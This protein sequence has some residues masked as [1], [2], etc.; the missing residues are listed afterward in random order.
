[1]LGGP[2]SE[3]DSCDVDEEEQ[4]VVTLEEGL[5]REVRTQLISLQDS[6]IS[7]VLG[8]IITFESILAIASHKSILVRTEA[9]KLLDLYVKRV[10]EGVRVSLVQSRAFDL[11]ANQLKDHRVSAPLL[12]A[13]FSI[14]F[15]EPFSISGNS[16]IPSVTSLPT[17]QISALIPVLACLSKTVERPSLCQAVIGILSQIYSKVNKMATFFFEN[18]GVTTLC[19]VVVV[20]W[21]TPNISMEEKNLLIKE[22]LQFMFAIANQS[23]R[24]SVE[25]LQT[26]RALLVCLD[27][28]VRQIRLR[29][30]RGKV[31]ILARTLHLLELLI[32][33]HVMSQTTVPHTTPVHIKTGRFSPR[34][35]PLKSSLH[36][37]NPAHLSGEGGDISS[38]VCE[39]LGVAVKHLLF[40]DHPF[41][42]QD[43][44]KFY[45][46]MDLSVQSV[47]QV[48][49]GR[50][51]TDHMDLAFAKFLTHYLH[52]SVYG[53]MT[54]TSHSHSH[55]PGSDSG[56]APHF[57]LSAKSALCEQYSTLLVCMLSPGQP[58][59]LHSAVFRYMWSLTGQKDVL[60]GLLTSGQ[61][62]KVLSCRLI[63]V[64]HDLL[65]HNQADDHSLSTL[66]SEIFDCVV[67]Q[68]ESS[69]IRGSLKL[70]TLLNPAVEADPRVRLKYETVLE[71]IKM[72]DQKG[73][74]D[75]SLQKKDWLDH[76]SKLYQRQ[77]SQNENRSR[78]I[79]SACDSVT[80]QTVSQQD[81]ARRNILVSMK[82]N[83]ATSHQ[84][85]KTWRR[86]IMLSTTPRGL[87]SLDE[88]RDMWYQVDPTEGPNRERRRLMRVPRSVPA[89][90]FLP[91]AVTAKEFDP[92]LHYLFE[93]V[94]PA[95]SVEVEEDVLSCVFDCLAIWPDK[96]CKGR[97]IITSNKFK[98]YGEGPL[99][100]PNMTKYLP[101]DEETVYQSWEFNEIVEYHRR[102]HELVDN[103]LEFFLSTGKT[104][105]LSFHSPETRNEVVSCMT[106]LVLPNLV[107]SGEGDSMKLK[108][109]TA[110]WQQGEMTNFEYLM[111]L[112]KLAGRSF[113]DLMQYP[114]FPFILSDYTSHN[115]NFLEPS[116]FRNFSLPI[117]VQNE[118]NIARYQK[119]YKE[120]QDV[121]NDDDTFGG[122]SPHHYSSHYSNSS[123]VLHYLVRI[124]PFT[125]LFLDFQGK[126]FD[127]ADRTFHSLLTS[128]ELS[129]SKS[130]SDVKELIPEFFYFPEFLT[131]IHGLN[132]GQRQTG[133]LVSD[134]ILPP[135]AEESARLFVLKHRQALESSHVSKHLHEW[136]DLIFGFK[137]QGRAAVAATNVFHPSTY[138]I[139]AA[140]RSAMDANL[141]SR[142]KSEVQM[143]GQMPLQL[144]KDPHPARHRTTVLRE[145][146]LKI[147]S[148]LRKIQES[149]SLFKN[150]T[151]ILISRHMLVCRP[152]LSQQGQDFIG[153]DEG[154]EPVCVY[155]EE[156]EFNH[157]NIFYLSGGEERVALLTPRAAFI[158]ASSRTYQ[159]VVVTWGNWD[160]AVH[161]LAFDGTVCKL[162]PPALDRLTCVEGGC[163]GQVLFT[164]GTLGVVSCWKLANTPTYVRY[165]GEVVH[166][167]G[168]EGPISCL[169][170]CRPFSIAVS[171]SVD[172][173]A[174]IWDTNRL[175]YVATLD[176]HEG[177]VVAMATSPTM[178]DIA[179]ATSKRVNGVLMSVLRIWTVN[180]TFVKS[181]EVYSEV[182][183]LAYT[184]A[185]EGVFVNSIVGGLRNGN[186][187]MWSSWDLSVIRDL[188]CPLDTSVAVLSL[189][190]SSSS[191]E[192]YAVF[193]DDTIAV[194]VKPE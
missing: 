56:Y 148:L 157:P 5:L 133:Q 60:G 28:Y 6:K 61:K 41:I 129:S 62:R 44:Q 79:E 92:P 189:T 43:V 94:S 3:G 193:K 172:G 89:K 155:Q 97:L 123:T 109:I 153:S 23:L 106:K 66:L 163:N 88:R 119:H 179:T 192:L 45:E 48:V 168:H 21:M 73:T 190:I 142:W 81:T 170:V 55:L 131:N 116:V 110:S 19:Q 188:K 1:M 125:Q 141:H 54:K 15:G 20:I 59:S 35:G 96:C 72:V 176:G 95:L 118:S 13:L 86:I 7:S 175:S 187:R 36:H 83:T 154:A 14:T 26:L 161:I 69:V 104:I 140:E 114:V 181:T 75:V 38:R 185:P 101:S 177:S 42:E 130:L 159:S 169:S 146:M 117:A 126:S 58:R 17:Y 180:G 49:T 67:R 139:S 167:R 82:R 160:N 10:D 166:L 85:L 164:G 9:I 63:L 4:V 111:E 70:S 71:D 32:L 52:L 127:I 171:G 84:V 151:S 64:V 145:F 162:Y 165:L 31:Q 16:A 99:E 91:G 77:Q 47:R 184:T 87:W 22:V 90:Y 39:V 136:V 107:D 134:V 18:Q 25:P 76:Q 50:I 158:Q 122:T 12:S 103:A 135:W 194:W 46:P 149:E 65:S 186:I 2:D 191:K 108:L 40:K 68:K 113:T 137:Q 53:V 147:G 183:C 29:Q 51:S 100:D 105:F 74:R 143:Y 182:Q 150:M 115:L 80:Q 27:N 144:F 178:G 112:N 152:R 173:T 138:I 30:P 11:L 132:F 98:F 124:P 33:Q 156:V 34:F 37:S 120:L 57:A 78:V 93:S 121:M 174:I 102:R 24:A 8:N 128:W